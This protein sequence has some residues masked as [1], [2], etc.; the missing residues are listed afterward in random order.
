MAGLPGV[1]ELFE[2]RHFDREIIVLCVRWVPALQAF[3]GEGP[4]LRVSKPY[5]KPSASSA[6]LQ[7]PMR[8]SSTVGRVRS[9]HA[10]RQ[11]SSLHLSAQSVGFLEFAKVGSTIVKARRIVTFYPEHN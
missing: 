6:G 8:L 7:S 2:G 10:D 9:R 11:D 5:D 3:R 1:D 4:K